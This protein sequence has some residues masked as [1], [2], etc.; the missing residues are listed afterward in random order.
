MKLA[1]Y[2]NKHGLENLTKA[3]EEIPS[4]WKELDPKK[5]PQAIYPK[6]KQ[7]PHGKLELYGSAEGRR[8][9]LIDTE[10]NMFRIIHNEFVQ[11]LSEW[12]LEPGLDRKPR[13]AIN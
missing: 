1:D 4:D 10:F 13:P 12:E 9:V 11:L 3:P 7:Y 5:T 2:I 8:Y 6:G